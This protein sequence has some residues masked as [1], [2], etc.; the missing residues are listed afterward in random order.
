MHRLEVI[1]SINSHEFEEEVEK[2]LNNLSGFDDFL[3][4][5]YSTNSV[6]NPL[7][8]RVTEYTAFIHYDIS[9]QSEFYL[10]DINEEVPEEQ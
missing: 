10:G 2:F 6:Q 8:V 5:T 9:T 1:S 4:V 7:G 3:K